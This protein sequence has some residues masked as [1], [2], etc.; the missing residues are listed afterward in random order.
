MRIKFLEN[1]DVDITTIPKESF[2]A[3]AIRHAGQRPEFATR[4][5]IN[6]DSKMVTDPSSG[7][8]FRKGWSA[9]LPDDMAARYIDAGQAQACD[10]DVITFASVE[11]MPEVSP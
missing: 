5:G 3:I 2:G 7:H 1:V 9:F 6:S 4:D 11:E 8:Y 10:R